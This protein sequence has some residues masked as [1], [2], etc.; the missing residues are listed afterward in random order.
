MVVSVLVD[1]EPVGIPPGIAVVDLVAYARIN[2]FYSDSGV[3][4]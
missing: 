1:S 2:D 3:M 4:K